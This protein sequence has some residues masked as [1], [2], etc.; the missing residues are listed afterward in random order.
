MASRTACKNKQDQ[1]ESPY[2]TPRELAQR[3]QCSRTSVDRIARQGGL[4][5]LCLG[6]GANGTIRYDREEVIAYEQSRRITLSR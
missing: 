5:R 6:S 3:W 1:A 4:S 2:I